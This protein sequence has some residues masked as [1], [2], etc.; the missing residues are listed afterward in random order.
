MPSRRARVPCADLTRPEVT[1]PSLQRA[2]ARRVL[3]RKAAGPS[4]KPEFCPQAAL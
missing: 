2:R 1:R 3:Q 4:A